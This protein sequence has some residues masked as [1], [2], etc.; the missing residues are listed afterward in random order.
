MEEEG[1]GHVLNREKHEAADSAMLPP[2]SLLC[3]TRDDC[4]SMLSP[5][6]FVGATIG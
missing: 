3:A 2:R 1:E 5:R 6:S 4:R